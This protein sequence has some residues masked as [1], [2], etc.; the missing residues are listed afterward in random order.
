MLVAGVVVTLAS[1][2]ILSSVVWLT[3]LGLAMLILAFILLALAR[4]IPRVPPEVG[5]LLLET[6]IDNIAAVVEELGIKSKPVYL[7][8][9]LTGG[10]PQ[11][12]IPLQDNPSPP[13]IT[14]ALPQRFIVR[15]GPGPDD[16]GLLVT[17]V[18]TIAAGM[19]ESPPGPS[20]D[21]LESALT[22]LLTGK[23]GA[24]D[25]ISVSLTNPGFR[26]EVRNPRVQSTGAS[27]HQ[28]LDSS[29][30]SVIASV[31]AEAWDGPVVV[32]REERRGRTHTIELETAG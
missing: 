8:S 11:A 31:A 15:Y 21:Q 22:S 2:F 32:A 16:V 14:E 4:T 5:V 3:A 18:G 12:L 25:R 17:T 10:R 30:A 20:P 24:A 19:L 27:S 6:G 9:S 23:L 1:L 26:V 29:L 7:P 13:K 28:C